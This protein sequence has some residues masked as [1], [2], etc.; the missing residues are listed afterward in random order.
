[1]YIGTMGLRYLF[2]RVA[3]FVA[4]ANEELGG[5]HLRILT[6][7]DTIAVTTMLR[8]AGVRD[9]S[10]SMDCVA[11]EKMPEELANQA[12]D[13]SGRERNY[14]TEY[15]GLWV[16]FHFSWSSRVEPWCGRF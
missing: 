5:V 11:H 7:T 2:H 1:V 8:D 13:A 3:R 4:I 6:R 12:E 14:R 10:W 16:N 9:D 15:E